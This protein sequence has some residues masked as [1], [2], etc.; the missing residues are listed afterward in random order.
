VVAD[1][2]ARPGEEDAL[3][4]GRARAGEDAAFAQLVGLH[5][6]SVEA[7]VRSRLG[8][9]AD[10]DDVVQES[11]VAAY[12]HLHDLTDDARF[13]PWLRRIASNAAAKALRRALV[14]RARFLHPANLEDVAW[15]GVEDEGGSRAPAYALREAMSALAPGDRAAVTLFHL[16]GLPQ[17]EIAEALE[18]PVGTVKSRLHRAKVQLR[19]RWSAM[20]N[21][22]GDPRSE[23]DYGRAVI[24]GM[25]GAIHWKKLLGD[26]GLEGWQTSRPECWRREGEVVLGEVKGHDGVSLGIG[27]AAWQDYELS[28]L[29]TLIKGGNAQIQFRCSADE[30]QFYVLDMLSGWQ[31]VAISRGDRRSGPR[32]KK[33]SVVNFPFDRG[34]EYDVMIAARDASLTSYIDGKLVNQLTDAS[35]P[36]GGI[37]LA[38]WQ[39]KTAFRDPRIRLLY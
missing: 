4:V 12:R 39:S 36:A 32:L 11:F 38:A 31:A 16:L 7:I 5:R 14:Q 17:T 19:R 6:P 10:V 37:R 33:L 8:A 29:V 20:T 30:Q 28:V 25:R 24:G 9:G 27:E 15:P 13:G 23:D 22:G 26:A 34:R 3:L 21:P 2:P 1:Q 35:L 18:V